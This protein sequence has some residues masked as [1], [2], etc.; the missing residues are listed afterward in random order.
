MLKRIVLLLSAVLFSGNLLWAQDF[1]FGF[2]DNEDISPNTGN[3]AS[4]GS[5]APSLSIG[6][7]V[8]AAII[9]YFNDII[10]GPEYVNTR[11]MFALSGKLNFNARSSV[12]EGI[13]NLNFVP[14][15]VPV[16]INEAY[17]SAFFGSFDISAGLKKLTWGK[18]DQFGP[19]D[20]IN[21]LD[22]SK[23]FIEM[24]DN[25]NLMNVKIANPVVQA[26]YR[27]GMFSKIE[28]VY[29]PS[30]DV[31]SMAI[32]TAMSGADNPMAAL[33]LGTSSQRWI[34]AQMS[35][36]NQMINKGIFG[37]DGNLLMHGSMK[38][39]NTSALDYTQAGLR[40]TTTIGRADIGAQYFYGRMFQPVVKMSVLQPDM[41]GIV[42]DP[43]APGFDPE[44]IPRPTA[45]AE[46]I[47]NKYHQ[48][49]LDYA[50]VILGFNIR[51]E[52]AANITEDLS[53]DDGY[54]YNPSIGWSFGFDRDLFLGINLNLQANGSVRLF[55]DKVGSGDNPFAPDFD[56]EAGTSMTATR[57]TAM[58][59]KKFLRDELELRG[60]VV[61]GIEDMDFAVIPALIWIKDDLKAALSGG[62]FLGDKEGQLGQYHTNNFL[63]ISATYT[64]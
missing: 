7:E 23:V 1:G 32:S 62:F 21:M 40:F 3:I 14:A 46:F 4:G 56:I 60:A 47:F 27:F 6:G 63:K 30:F 51:A 2:N 8:S 29:L 50:Q 36:L 57:L 41:T 54:I 20:V 25:N 34:P 53:G 13:I 19:L 38:E 15:F 48:I 16:S 44:K 22:A 26:S 33:L 58:L 43:T 39:I 18:A 31:V 42:I 24:A 64:F 12:A 11:D 49:G 45:E 61:W 9:G 5:Y 10:E 35:E 37:E 28:A 52:A 59:S 17:L 55:D